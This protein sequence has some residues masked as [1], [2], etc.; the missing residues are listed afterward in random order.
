MAY[1]GVVLKLRESSIF[2]S[3]KKTLTLGFG[4]R[5]LASTTVPFKLRLSRILPVEKEKIRLSKTLPSL[6]SLIH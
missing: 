3:C 2:D 5:V 6:I 4:L 1:F